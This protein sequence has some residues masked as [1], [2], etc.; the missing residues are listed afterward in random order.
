RPPSGARRVL[1]TFG[2]ILVLGVLFSLGPRFTIVPLYELSFHLVPYWQL[3]RQPAKF[4]VVAALALGVL[5][6]VGADRLGAAWGGRRAAAALCGALALGIAAEYHPWR[7][8]GLSG[9][10]QGGLVF[11]TIRDLGPRALYVPLW[12]GDS[13]YSALYLHTTTLTRVPMVNGYSP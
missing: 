8:V 5:A 12:P 7:P 6:A 3:I 4:Q 10:P 1:L 2:P 13:S 9:L 11:D